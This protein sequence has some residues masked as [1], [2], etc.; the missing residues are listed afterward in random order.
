MKIILEK[1]DHV[2]L[3][4]NEKGKIVKIKN[5]IWGFP[6]VVKITH[7]TGWN[8][9]GSEVDYRLDQLELDTTD[10]QFSTLKPYGL[11]IAKHTEAH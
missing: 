8:T 5:L 9:K 1:G 11:D 6:I 4:F 3:P 2:L 7:S 10:L